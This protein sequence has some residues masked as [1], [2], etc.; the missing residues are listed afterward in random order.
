MSK[1]R[2][3]MDAVLQGDVPIGMQVSTFQEFVSPI[4]GTVI[5]SKSQLRDHEKRYNVRQV[6][7]D[8]VGKGNHGSNIR[9][10]GK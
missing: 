6:G 5:A 2:S 10:D 1:R 3:M 9:R 7:N 4:D 8:L